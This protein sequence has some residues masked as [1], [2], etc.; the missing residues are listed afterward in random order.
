[1]NVSEIFIRRPI[2]TSLLMLAIALFG[3]VAYR[4]LPVSD[5]P[6][7]DFPTLVVTAS[8]PGANPDTMASA[9]ATPLERQFSTIAG[10]D[11]MSSTS[12][13]GVTLV[14]LQFDLSRN[15]D[16]AAVD[17]QTGIT[18]ASPYLPPGMPTPPT[19]RKVNPADQPILYLA[20]TSPTLPLYTL[21]EY[22]E[23]TIAQRI[24]M[25]NGVAQV[26]V[27][28][29][30]KYAVHAQMDPR[31]LAAKQI[32][33]DEVESA[34]QKWNVNLPTGTL[35]G[36]NNAFTVLANGQLMSAAQYRPLVVAYRNGAPVRLEQLG[37]VIDSVEDDKTASWFYSRHEAGRRSMILAI[38]R[39]PGTNTVEV[40]N[41]IKRLLP[42]FEAQMP[43]SVQMH[44]LYDRSLSIRESFN[45]V[46]FTLL[47]T[48]GLVIMVIFLFLRNLSA[49]AIPSLALP[50][51]IIGTFSIMYLLDF[52]LDNLS[53]M[54][55]I[56]CVG[57]VVDDAI[58][59][60]ENIVRH[61]EMGVA[62]MQASF[63]GSREIGFTIVSMTL[64]LAAVFI[65]VLFMGG[66]LGRLF[67]EFAV[68]ICA[69][70]LISGLV[71][72]TL[73]PMLCSRFLRVRH[74][75]AHG[76][77][78][79]LT[80]RFFDGMLAGYDRSLQAVLRHRP[81]MMILFAAILAATGWLFVK[82]PKGFIPDQDND[83]IF[84]VTEAAQGTSFEQMKAY[85]R[86]ISD[87]G[88]HD[89]NVEEFMSSVGGTSAA[90]LGGPNFGR[91]FFHLTPRAQ[92]ALDVTRVMEELRPK[93][94]GFPG[95]RVFMQ[96][97]PTIRIGGQL[98][99]S[100]YQVTMQGPDTAEL[101]REA[102]RLERDAA[103]LPGL[104]DVTSDLQIKNP[105]VHIEIDRDKAAA[106]N[107]SAAQIESALY[108]AYGPHWISTIYAPINQYKV[109]L[110]LM[111]Q[112]QATADAISLIYLRSGSGKLVPIDTVTRMTRESGPQ[113]INHFGQLPAVTVSFNLK[114]GAS[115]GD[116]VGGIQG[117]IDRLPAT[118]SANFQ[119]TAKAFQSSL[120]N[121]W[122]LLIIAI[123]VVYIVLGI[124]Y[125]SYIH[126]I[127]ILSGLPSAGFG[128]L[129]TLYLFHIDLS[130]YAF[131]G[132]IMLIGIVK[133]NAIMQIDFALAAE[134]QEGKTPMEAIYSG[135]LIR[136]RPI[137][138][139]TMAALLGAVPIALGYGAGGE[140]RKPL[141]MSVV[142]GLIF[143]QLITLYLTPVVYT[144]LAALTG[145]GSRKKGPS[146]PVALEPK[147]VWAGG[148]G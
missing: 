47:L 60:L 118:I 76:S 131:V 7:V 93:L 56:L 109:L 61:M 124:L 91:M 141:G 2:A 86:L 40:T 9:V 139:T 46:Q 67:K 78:Y 39:Q 117:L 132:L 41:S 147:E 1:M 105:Q 143:S 110:E 89:P 115:L 79:G 30:Q 33:I 97:P 29:A 90:S 104:Q 37:R 106:V 129:L 75:A 71:S 8:L 4:A 98:T 50:F 144:Y 20:L 52:S 10:L 17:V 112:Y 25:I 128:A 83:Q 134:R 26:S 130:I 34:I 32:G 126:P 64:S 122:L 23:T 100:L 92:R 49:T 54:A 53:M 74:G 59:M 111:P 6:N 125:E 103:R 88:I 133:K 138:M 84:V 116:A 127:T 95:V 66:I 136:F 36:Q 44:I 58:V 19:F 35:F 45:D 135:C 137:M 3:L 65:P 57:F 99:K 63:E 42:V 145:H 43:P 121:L 107:V 120:G 119:G 15:L 70:I 69:A 94:S 12:S 96:N 142:G 55:L 16:G 87:V 123:L 148:K 38:Q 51:S 21:D 68:T 13:L 81:V 28:G 31:L 77:L 48:L 146:A 14:T 101:Y 102:Q 73:T 140:A 72:V 114:P 27:F 113:T 11:T 82:V 108:D 5:L 80:E 24:S 18:Q 62:P 85:Q 22:A